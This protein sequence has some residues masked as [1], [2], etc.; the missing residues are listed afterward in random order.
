[1]RV[2][3]ILESHFSLTKARNITAFGVDNS[4]SREKRTKNPITYSLL[5]RYMS[6]LVISIIPMFQ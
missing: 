2:K 3:V 5:H 1:M 6:A 4:V